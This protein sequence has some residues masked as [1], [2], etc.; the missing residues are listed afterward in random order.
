MVI[1]FS[2]FELCKPVCSRK[3]FCD[4]VRS[5]KAK[6]KDIVE[7]PCNPKCDKARVG[8]AKSDS[9]SHMQ[10]TPGNL[11]SNRAHSTVVKHESCVRR[12]VHTKKLKQPLPRF[13]SLKLKC[14]LPLCIIMCWYNKLLQSFSS[15][16]QLPMG[17]VR[18]H[19]FIYACIW[20]QESEN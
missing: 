5:S 2:Q 16:C 17:M 15:Q 4:V 1:C 7:D 10:I 18:Y 8:S 3:C 12:H 13:I 20:L 14:F 11:F 6:Q 19:P 9:S